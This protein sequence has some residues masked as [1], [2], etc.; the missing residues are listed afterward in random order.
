M[1]TDFRLFINDKAK[2]LSA[3]SPVALWLGM[4]QKQSGPWVQRAELLLT[5]P[6][7]KSQHFSSAAD[8]VAFTLSPLA[9]PFPLLSEDTFLSARG[10]P[11]SAERDEQWSLGN[12]LPAIPP[13][14]VHHGRKG[15]LKH[16]CQ[17]QGGW[18]W[19][20]NEGERPPLFPTKQEH[21]GERSVREG[22]L[23]GST[24]G[25][26]ILLVHSRR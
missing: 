5:N 6:R 8:S 10:I 14:K 1:Q 22:S 3:L 7:G 4:T 9:S 18:S 12:T 23:C 13:N 15:W 26:H 11:Y 17:T 16:G 19:G 2:H 21:R 24:P 20:K 25:F